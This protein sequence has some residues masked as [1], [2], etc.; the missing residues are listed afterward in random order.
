MKPG[1]TRRGKNIK[2]GDIAVGDLVQ[3]VRPRYNKGRPRGGNVV[4]LD[5]PVERGFG[6]Y[7]FQVTDG[8]HTD[9]T[10]QIIDH[11]IHLHKKWKNK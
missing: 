2:Y 9:K 5:S 3:W 11:Q 7:T 6:G 10:I 1:E 8:L 4:S